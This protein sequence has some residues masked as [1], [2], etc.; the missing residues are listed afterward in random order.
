MTNKDA[1]ELL[2]FLLDQ[3]DLM[4]PLEGKSGKVKANATA[5]TKQKIGDFIDICKKYKAKLGHWPNTSSQETF[6][7]Q[8]PEHSILIEEVVDT[9]LEG[10][11]KEFLTKTIVSWITAWQEVEH[12]TLKVDLIQKRK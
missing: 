5:E 10:I 11:D 1:L 2:R 12:T 6:K 3:P 8:F 4:D 7:R 9:N